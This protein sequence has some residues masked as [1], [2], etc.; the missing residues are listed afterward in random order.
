MVDIA[1]IVLTIQA[2]LFILIVPFPLLYLLTIIFIQRFHTTNNI[3]TTN[4]C[5]TCLMCTI[6]WAIEKTSSI[7]STRILYG[8]P[9]LCALTLSVGQLV[10]CLV[11]HSLGVITVSRCFTICFPMK[12]FFKSKAWVYLSI[13]AQWIFSLLVTIPILLINIKRCDGGTGFSNWIWFYTLSLI[14]ILPVIFN[15]IFNGIIVIFVRL[16][17]RRVHAVTMSVAT[18]TDTSHQQNRRDIKLLKHILFLFIVFIFG[19]GPLYIALTMR[20]LRIPDWL[21]NVLQIPPTFTVIIQV[22]DI[23]IYTHEVRQYWKEQIKR[24]L[25]TIVIN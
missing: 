9:I 8:T 12:R 19:W 1:F 23:F 3:L 13:I 24:C 11:V 18:G 21:Y 6:Y 15:I 20:D 7:F 4:F 14:V 22:V 2:I 5:L 25:H 10:N 17:T 16:S